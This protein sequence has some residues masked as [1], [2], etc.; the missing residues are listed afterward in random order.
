MNDL[1]LAWSEH[2]ADVMARVAKLQPESFFATSAR[3]CP[4]NV[5]LSIEQ[6]FSGGLDAT[7]ISIL[8]AIGEAVPDADSRSPGEVL[9][10]VAEAVRAHSAT[11]IEGASD[12][13]TEDIEGK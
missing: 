2:G 11:T 3:L 6:Q 7:D 4:A 1:H 13:Q 10:F 9:T 5:Q 12:L 8:K